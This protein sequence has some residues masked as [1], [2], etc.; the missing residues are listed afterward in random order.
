MTSNRE[1]E[2][3]VKARHG[4]VSERMQEHAI[5]KVARLARYNDQVTRIEVLADHP[6]ESPEVELLVHMRSGA[7]MVAKDRA[8]SFATAVDQVAEKME[9]LLKKHKEK[10][11]EHKGQ[12]GVTPPDDGRGPGGPDQDVVTRDRKG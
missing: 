4:Q 8:D 11:K 9:R 12:P 6:H 3:E 2:V 7:P 10:L 1:V 5:K